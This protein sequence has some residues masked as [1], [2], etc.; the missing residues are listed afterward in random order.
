V[1]DRGSA[2]VLTLGVIAVVLVLTVGLV[3]VGAVLRT[4]VEAATAADAAALAAA[5]LTFY[6]FGSGAGPRAE[7][8]RF[9]ALNGARLVDCDCAVDPSWEPRTV[10]VVVESRVHLPALPDIRVRASSR[11]EFVP[12]LLLSPV[13][14]PS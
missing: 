6:P 5:P 1:T 14:E 4:R 12:A 3:V 11:A 13:V 8:A 10:Q 9:A 7:A 2:S